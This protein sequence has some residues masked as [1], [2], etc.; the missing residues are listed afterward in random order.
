MWMRPVEKSTVTGS[1]DLEGTPRACA[2]IERGDRVLRV[3]DAIRR[4]FRRA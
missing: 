1:H 4:A 2:P 3:L